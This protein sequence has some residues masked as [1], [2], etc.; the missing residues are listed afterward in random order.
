[1]LSVDG[2]RR[3]REPTELRQSLLV[4]LMNYARYVD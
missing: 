2:E 4:S 3:K 1:M